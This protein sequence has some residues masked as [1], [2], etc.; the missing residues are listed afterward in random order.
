MWWCPCSHCCSMASLWSSADWACMACSW[1]AADIVGGI[2]AGRSRGYGVPGGRPNT[3]NVIR[4]R[5]IDVSKES[6]H[7]LRTYQKLGV[8]ASRVRAAAGPGEGWGWRRVGKGSVPGEV[9]PGDLLPA[10]GRRNLEDTQDI[11]H[12]LLGVRVLGSGYT[13][14]KIVYH[15]ACYRH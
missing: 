14:Y 10:D 15:T 12:H 9:Q 3:E 1:W 8:A 6:Q 11:H 7:W 4:L 5:L 13:H 2:P